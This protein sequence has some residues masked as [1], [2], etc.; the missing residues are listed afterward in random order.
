MMNIISSIKIWAMVIALGG[1]LS[2]FKI[3]D[4][5]LFEGEIKSLKIFVRVEIKIT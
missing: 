4:K 1:T 3:I 2:S 5:G